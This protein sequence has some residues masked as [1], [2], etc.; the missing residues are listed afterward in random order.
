MLELNFSPFPVITTER[1]LLR[2]MTKQDAGEIFLLRSN[3]LIA[4]V[5]TA[6]RVVLALLVLLAAVGVIVA[7][8]PQQLIRS[9]IFLRK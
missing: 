5:Q 4:R 7:L 1:L 8:L 2:S 3:E 6:F 9:K